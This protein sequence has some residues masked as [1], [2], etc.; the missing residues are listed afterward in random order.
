MTNVS[1]TEPP[2]S[3]PNTRRRRLQYTLRTLIIV[4]TV[5]AAGMSLWAT[6]FRKARRQRQIVG[7]ILREGGVVTYDSESEA[8]DGSWAEQQRSPIT[9][10]ARRIC[11][12]IVTL[13]SN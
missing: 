4:L 11:G 12:E 3:A 5:A 2:L 13:E 8:S 1:T 9:S 10:F 6:I 7:A